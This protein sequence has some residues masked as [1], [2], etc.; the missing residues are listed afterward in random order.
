MFRPRIEVD[1][2]FS[3]VT[4]HTKGPAS[5]HT[6][7]G[8]AVELFQ[9]HLGTL[10]SGLTHFIGNVSLSL[11]VSVSPYTFLTMGGNISVPPPHASPSCVGLKCGCVE[12]E[13]GGRENM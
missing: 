11:S 1:G 13:E 7:T 2:T 8:E 10:W 6:E 3:Q 9:A 5:V 4:P 12:G